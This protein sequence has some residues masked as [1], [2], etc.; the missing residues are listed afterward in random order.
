MLTVERS[1]EVLHLVECYWPGVTETKLAAAADRAADGRRASCVE[2][3]LIPADEI[4]LCLYR[5]AS[6]AVVGDASRRAGLPTERIVRAV[7]IKPTDHRN[8]D[9]WTDNRTAATHRDH[10]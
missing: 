1:S 8:H 9:P 5:A 7:C 3:L 6:A 10:P 4:V 2:L